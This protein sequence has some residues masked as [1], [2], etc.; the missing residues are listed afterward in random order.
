MKKQNRRWIC[1]W[2]Q[3][4]IIKWNQIHLNSVLCLEFAFYWKLSWRFY[5]SQ[6]TSKKICI[7]NLKSKLENKKHLVKIMKCDKTNNY[8][9]SFTENSFWLSV[10]VNHR[11]KCTH[12]S[13]HNSNYTIH[14]NVKAK[15][16]NIHIELKNW[17]TKQNK[18]QWHRRKHKSR[19][20]KN[21]K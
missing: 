20:M 16:H 2:H 19:D 5:F 21:D 17:H 9:Y 18:T 6:A 7:E 10:C 3:E 13:K 12:Q 1:Q 15:R 8:F 4:S 14:A 11:I